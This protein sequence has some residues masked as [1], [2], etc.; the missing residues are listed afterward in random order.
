[1]REIQK[2]G[3]CLLNREEIIP[4]NLGR[5]DVLEVV[6]SDQLTTMKDEVVCTE[7]ILCDWL[8]WVLPVYS[9]H[10]QSQ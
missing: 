10:K 8:N 1:M 2:G 6:R 4:P 9:T 5:R 7:L 3:I